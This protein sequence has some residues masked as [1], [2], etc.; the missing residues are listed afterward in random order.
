MEIKYKITIPKPC[1][2]NWDEMTPRENG[3]FCMSCSK[4]VVDFSTMNPEEIRHYFT[5]HQNEKICGRF[6]KSQLDTI[7]IQIPDRILYA[8]T[9]YYKM[10]L[11]ALFISMGTTL[12]SCSDKNGNKKKIDKIEIVENKKLEERIVEKELSKD[13]IPIPV[14]PKSIPVKFV[15]PRPIVCGEAFIDKDNSSAKIKD[16]NTTAKD[17]IVEDGLYVMGASI[18]T[19]PDYP[20]GINNFYQFFVSEFKLP[21][22]AENPKS[23][24]L[25]NFVIEKD[26]SLSSFEFPKDIDPKIKLE[27]TRVLNLS[28]KWQSGTQ[29]GKR[30][31]TKYSFPIA[32]QS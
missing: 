28:P 3:R 2:E 29:N 11:L 6:K 25:I 27:I 4:T 1:H 12:F 15:K 13:S 18:E 23:K 5:E 19:S 20:S 8:Q 26:G 30:T 17:S 7:T 31:R 22:E 9:Q 32:I 21:E 14:L 16:Q 24:I 10:F